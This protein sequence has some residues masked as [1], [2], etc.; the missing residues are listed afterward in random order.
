MELSDQ[1]KK[2]KKKLITLQFYS[3]KIGNVTETVF[4]PSGY[5]SL[6]SIRLQLIPALKSAKSLGFLSQVWSFNSNKANDLIKAGIPDLCLIGKLNTNTKDLKHN[7]YVANCAAL[8]LYH[9]HNVPIVTIY[10]DN[11]AQRKDLVGTLYRFIL[12]ISNAVVFPTA[13]LRDMTCKDLLSSKKFIIEDPWQVDFYNY[14]SKNPPSE[15]FKI[16]W[17]GT[18]SNWK[19]LANILQN[20]IDIVPKSNKI[21]FT[22]LT[23]IFMMEIISNDLK[24]LS[25]DCTKFVFRLV[26]WDFTNQPKQLENEL[27]RSHIA[28]IPSDPSDPAKMGVSHNRVVDAVRSGCLT[29]CSPLNSYKE[30][31][32]IAL[33][34]HNLPELINY[35]IKNYKEVSQK[36]LFD[37]ESKVSRFSPKQNFQKWTDVLKEFC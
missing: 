37:V 19:Y 16:I 3:N 33:V 20:I 15:Q 10:S 35:G 7:M 4:A 22:I 12:K 27:Q 29:I 5:S 31:N 14:E 2:R 25:F 34:G 6:A 32:D 17:F 8:Q 36:T 26:N 21:E 24:N 13:T 18:G 9:D 30:L 23:S 28:I 11:H 1:M